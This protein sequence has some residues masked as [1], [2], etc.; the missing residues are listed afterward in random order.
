M[1]RLSA[2]YFLCLLAEIA[3]SF[4]DNGGREG[5][6][7][8]SWGIGG[9]WWDVHVPLGT[10]SSVNVAGYGDRDTHA[11]GGDGVRARCVHVS[12]LIVMSYPMEVM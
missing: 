1:L 4:L 2:E 5:K 3:M 7:G 9:N 6:G 8:A 10:V 11:R 12:L